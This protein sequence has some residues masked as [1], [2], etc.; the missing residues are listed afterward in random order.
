M[1]IKSP[2]KVFFFE[3]RPSCGKTQL[4]STMSRKQNMNV[5]FKWDKSGSGG[6]FYIDANKSH[7][8]MIYDIWSEGGVFNHMSHNMQEVMAVDA[9]YWIKEELSISADPV[10]ISLIGHVDEPHDGI[11]YRSSYDDLNIGLE[12]SKRDM[13]EYDFKKLLST[14]LNDPLPDGVPNWDVSQKGYNWLNDFVKKIVL[15]NFEESE[16]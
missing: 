12:A 11:V 8:A 9:W 16:D 2:I 10:S 5:N 13:S 15:S 4:F 1:S 6:V 7:L 14:R 3:V